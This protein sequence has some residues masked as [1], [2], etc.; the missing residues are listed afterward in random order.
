MAITLVPET[1]TGLANANTFATDAEYQ[2]YCND[3]GYAASDDADTR[4]I[5]LITA[6]EYLR[7]ED[8]YVYRG[9]RVSDTQRLPFPRSGVVVLYGTG[10]VFPSNVVPGALKDAQCELAYRAQ[11]TVIQPDL[12]RGGAIASVS[13][14]G[15]VS[16]SYMST[17]LKETLVSVALGVL[18]PWLRRMTNLP[19]APYLS[20]DLR[21][22][23]D[24]SDARIRDINDGVAN[25][26]SPLTNDASAPPTEVV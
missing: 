5:A 21:G 20:L 6:A 1:G 4:A 14:G 9:Q 10:A 17:A 11:S 16:V 25:R 18:K 24:V 23:Q 2:A 19:I 12:D 15:G 13:A 7:N 26:V 3:H 22:Y 8:R